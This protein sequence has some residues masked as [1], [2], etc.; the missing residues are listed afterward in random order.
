[1]GFDSSETILIKIYVDEYD[2]NKKIKSLEIKYYFIQNKKEVVLKKTI[3]ELLGKIDSISVKNIKKIMNHIVEKITL[4]DDEDNESIN[5]DLLSDDE[6]NENE[7]EKEKENQDNDEKNKI[8]EKYNEEEI[9]N[10]DEEFN[11]ENN[12]EN[13][14]KKEENKKDN[15]SS[16]GDVDYN[17]I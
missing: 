8:K 11:I 7:K 3:K 17:D 13:N 10:D 2:K 16:I 1:M 6:E 5:L 14:N 15:D 9:I 12:E 4:D